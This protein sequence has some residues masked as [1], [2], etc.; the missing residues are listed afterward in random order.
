MLCRLTSCLHIT[1]PH[2]AS[3]LRMPYAQVIERCIASQAVCAWLRLILRHAHVFCPGRWIMLR[4]LT[5]VTF[6]EL[7]SEQ[8]GWVAQFPLRLRLRG[9]KMADPRRSSGGPGSSVSHHA[10]KGWRI[11]DETEIKKLKTGKERIPRQ[12]YSVA[13]RLK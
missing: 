1:T 9:T 2:P 12:V 3:D 4:H 11:A 13:M 10:W 7:S 6:N 5:Q 8:C